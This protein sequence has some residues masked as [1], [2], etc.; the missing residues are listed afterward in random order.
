MVS[1]GGYLDQRKDD[2]IRIWKD[3]SRIKRDPFVLEEY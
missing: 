3:D 1:D 2:M